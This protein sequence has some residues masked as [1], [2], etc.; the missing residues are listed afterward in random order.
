[1]K[2]QEV[3]KQMEEDYKTFKQNEKEK[4]LR[5]YHL[6]EE[7]HIS[8]KEAENASNVIKRNDPS[9]NKITYF[10]QVY[11][12]VTDEELDYLK[13]IDINHKETNKENGVYSIL[14]I[15]SIIIFFVGVIGG[16]FYASIG[17][18][19]LGTLMLIGAVLQALFVLGFAEIINLLH[20]INLK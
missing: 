11:E 16:I 20:K 4:L 10:K 14:F 19:G 2:Y 15:T 3:K 1:M 7:I 12:D 13:S 6:Y 5:H 8:P 17:E 18:Q 9:T